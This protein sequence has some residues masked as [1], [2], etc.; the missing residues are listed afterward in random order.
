MKN[1]KLDNYKFK[2]GLF[3][4]PFNDLPGLKLGNWNYERLPSFFWFALILQKYGHKEG[5]EICGKII[6]YV[7]NNYKLD[8]PLFSDILKLNKDQQEVFFEYILTLVDA[9]TLYPLTLIFS[10]SKY[11]NFFKHFFIKDIEVDRKKVLIEVIR[12]TYD[13]QSEISTDIRFL[14]VWS[15]VVAGKMKFYKGLTIVDVLPKYPYTSHSEEIMGLW[16][17]TVRATEGGMQVIVKYDDNFN[18]R[19]WK[20]I[21]EMTDC[22]LYR[23]NYE[24]NED[25]DEIKK[26]V[27]RIMQIAKYYNDLFKDFH[28]LDTK[29]EVLISIFCYS[30]KRVSEL[31]NHNLFNQISGRSIIRNIIENYIMMK[32]LNVEEK[33]H[34][35]IWREFMSYGYGQLNLIL[36]KYKDEQ[37]KV[38]TNTH[39]NVEY[40]DAIINSETDTKFLDMDTKYFNKE[41]IRVKAEKVDEKELFDFYYDYDSQFEHGLWGA[42]RES[43]SIACNN[44]THRYH[45]TIDYENIQNLSSVWEDCK[46]VMNMTVDYLNSIYPLPQ[47]LL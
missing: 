46:K 6:N 23:F 8:F 45:H 3:I 9:E 22:E 11:P 29:M 12:S 5:L 14:I 41:N 10:Y 1:I 44:P 19:F 34:P 36:I 37:R 21:S 13:N 17:S 27:E 40:I 7:Y 24:Q 38:P 15:G 25:L 28:P 42:I 35:D 32:Y 20:E 31:V 4:A 33:N 47:K 26:Y 30:Y 39:F 18:K 16:R 43:V 2:K